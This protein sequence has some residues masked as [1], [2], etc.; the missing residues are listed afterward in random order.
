MGGK[1]VKE[2]CENCRF[3]KLFRDCA[4]CAR[5]APDRYNIAGQSVSGHPKVGLTDWCGDW[6]PQE[7]RAH[8][9]PDDDAG[10]CCACKQRTPYPKM[11]HLTPDTKDLNQYFLI[12][13]DCMKY[14]SDFYETNMRKEQK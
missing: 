11:Y 6:E 12:C 5:H 13:T 14:I 7:K 2:K 1:R 8:A 10:I 4:Q 3:I 9:M